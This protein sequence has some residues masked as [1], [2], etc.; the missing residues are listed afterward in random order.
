MNA[1]EKSLV[2]LRW[3]QEISLDVLLEKYAKGNETSIADVRKPY[4]KALASVE[5]P[6]FQAYYEEKFLWAQKMVLSQPVVSIRLRVW[7][8]AQP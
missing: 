6:D 4:A 1:N 7:I 2:S 3:H 5:A 8:C